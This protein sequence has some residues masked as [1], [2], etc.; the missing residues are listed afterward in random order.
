MSIGRD[1][2]SGA[3]G[4]SDSSSSSDL[5]SKSNPFRE[6]IDSPPQDLLWRRGLQSLAFALQ[7]LEQFVRGSQRWIGR[8]GTA[9]LIRFD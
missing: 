8:Q 4:T 1:D 2:S 3:A 5:K 7:I 6:T 9:R